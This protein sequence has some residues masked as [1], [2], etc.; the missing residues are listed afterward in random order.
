MPILIALINFVFHF[1]EKKTNKSHKTGDEPVKHLEFIDEYDP[2]LTEI[3]KGRQAE[4]D[5]PFISE[6]DGTFVDKVTRF[7][8]KESETMRR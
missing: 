4:L 3:Y 6:S 1:L 5:E 7:L 2:L 8:R